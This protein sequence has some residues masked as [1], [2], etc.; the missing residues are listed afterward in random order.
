M[1][2]GGAVV[3]LAVCACVTIRPSAAQETSAA[4]YPARSIT[5][6]MPL[7]AGSAGDMLG[8]LVGAKMAIDLGRP[9]VSE[10]VTGASGA[11][12]IERVLRAAP[13]GY[14]LLGTG[15]NQL[16]YAPLFNK[17]ARFD[18]RTDLAPIT[19]LAVLDWALVVNPAFP[20]KTISELTAL[21][22]GRPGVI[23]FAS[24]GVGSAQQIA[25]ELLMARSGIKLTHV[26]YRGVTPALN[27]VV[28][29]V[30]PLIFTAVS[31]AA[32]YLPDGKL[33]V[34]ATTGRQRSTLLP[35]VPTVAESGLAG[36]EF[37][38][39]MGLL[40]PRDTP[41]VIVERINRA[42]ATAVKDASLRPQ[43]AAGGFVPV[44][45]SPAEFRAVLASD[46][47]RIADVVREASLAPN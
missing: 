5:M 18:P 15:D 30:V 21:A 47:A 34:L 6:V 10:N 14:T 26:P 38:T 33:R 31:V 19:Q 43:M 11:I 46:Y 20:A 4:D 32:P 40:A 12:G 3:V 29:G 36:F 25:M 24:G 39:W 7:A 35:D 22:K 37:T 9:I 44:G 17:S 13:D 2:L 42:A 16:I 27:D 28:A 1:G 45:N 23:N 41:T 8:R